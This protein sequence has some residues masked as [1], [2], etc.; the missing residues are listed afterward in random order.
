MVRCVELG[1]RGKRKV[2]KADGQVTFSPL[3]G[4][5]FSKVAIAPAHA[6]KL[7]V[8]ICLNSDF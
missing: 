8:E 4:G 5:A 6:K 2:E 1:R 7:E 3:D